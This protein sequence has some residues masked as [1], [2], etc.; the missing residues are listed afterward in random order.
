MGKLGYFPGRVRLHAYQ[1]QLITSDDCYLNCCHEMPSFTTVLHEIPFQTGAPSTAKCK[2]LFHASCFPVLHFHILHFH[3]FNFHLLRSA[4]SHP[5]FS[6][7][8]FSPREICI[9]MS[10]IF[11]SC[12]FMPRNFDG[13]SFSRP[14]FSVDPLDHTVGLPSPDPCFG[15]S[16][17]ECLKTPLY[18]PTSNFT[19]AASLPQFRSHK[20]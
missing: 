16:R 4:F 11:M 17:T 12:I 3:V 2:Q 14:A 20:L 19:L 1:S 13:P 8:S 5:A 15:P 18:G 7:L 10:C 6:R 9:F